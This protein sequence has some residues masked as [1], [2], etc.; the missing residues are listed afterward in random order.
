MLFRSHG[1]GENGTDGEKHLKVGL[2]PYVLAKPGEI[3]QLLA[4]AQAQG[5]D[6]RF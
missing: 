4:K 3:A 6:Q 1:V 2:P 5:A